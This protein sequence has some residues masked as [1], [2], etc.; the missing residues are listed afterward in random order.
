MT[1]H[2]EPSSATIQLWKDTVTVYP[3]FPKP[4]VNFLDIAPLM[5]DPVIWDNI[6]MDIVRR[7]FEVEDASPEDE[8]FT[9][10]IGLDARGFIMGS[11]VADLMGLPFVMA[12]KPG[13]LPGSLLTYH[14]DLEY[15]SNSLSIQVG[16]IPAGSLVAVVDDLLATGGT[17]EAACELVKMAG[18][19]AGF[20]GTV[21]EL[22]A[23]KGRDRLDPAI[24]IHSAMKF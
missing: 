9:H 19:K 23:L 22:T 16:A 13:K 10:V 18:A 7:L 14:Y 2:N 21:I 4:G 5:A 3:N 15:G 1:V 8:I 20:I 12:R 11:R 6:T 17:L 24:P